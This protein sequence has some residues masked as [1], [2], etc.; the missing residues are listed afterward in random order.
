MGAHK[1]IVYQL[2]MDHTHQSDSYTVK[3]Q[4]R[5]NTDMWSITLVLKVALK[6]LPNKVIL[7]F[8]VIVINKT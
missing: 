8:I 7:W 3:I 5:F 2:N 1:S 6:Y 4:L